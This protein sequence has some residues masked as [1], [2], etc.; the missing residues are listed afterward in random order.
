MLILL[1]MSTDEIAMSLGISRPSVNSARY[2]IRK[3]LHLD[4]DT[5]LDTFIKSRIRQ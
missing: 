3:R 5:D 4:K 1:N 2:R